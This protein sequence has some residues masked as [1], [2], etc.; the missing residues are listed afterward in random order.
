MKNT[1]TAEGLRRDLL[2]PCVALCFLSI[3]PKLQA[4]TEPDRLPDAQFTCRPHLGFPLKHRRLWGGEDSARLVDSA[5][6]EDGVALQTQ[7]K[8]IPFH[9][10][11]DWKDWQKEESF[12][13]LCNMRK[14]GELVL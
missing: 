12:D 5:E 1:C 13:S 6:D 9:P 3:S 7:S 11:S 10:S 4:L 2:S 8:G 14:R